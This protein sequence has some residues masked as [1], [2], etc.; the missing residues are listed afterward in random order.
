MTA[1]ILFYIP[2][3]VVTCIGTLSN[4][5]IGNSLMDI[6]EDI[7][8]LCYYSNNLINSFIYYFTLKEFRNGYNKLLC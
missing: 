3:I 5:F 2:V 1:Y 8:L 4:A 7:S 6:V